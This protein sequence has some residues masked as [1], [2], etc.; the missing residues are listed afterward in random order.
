MAD[1]YD[2]DLMIQA[3]QLFTDAIAAHDL[4]YEFAEKLD[5][6]YREYQDKDEEAVKILKPLK[7]KAWVIAQSAIVLASDFQNSLESFRK[8][9]PKPKRKKGFDDL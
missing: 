1:P 9:H 5:L 8:T 7:R 3:S 2:D 4:V 6:T